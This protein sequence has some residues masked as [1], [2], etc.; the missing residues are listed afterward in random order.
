[1]HT[2]LLLLLAILPQ[3]LSWSAEGHQLT[4]KVALSNLTPHAHSFINT[5]LPPGTDLP[6]TSTYADGIKF[7][8]PWSRRLHYVQALPSQD[9]P[10]VCGYDSGRD[11]KDGRCL[12][13]TIQNY[14]RILECGF[15]ASDEEKGFAISFLTHYAG[16]L[17]QP[18]HVCKRDNGGL[19]LGFN[20]RK[21]SQS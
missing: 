2:P 16:D 3:V 8:H 6:M 7:T 11:C 4:A 14:T 20:V 19:I 15:D 21:W 10:D 9:E 12:T 1:M 5:F 17:V 13:A 18:L